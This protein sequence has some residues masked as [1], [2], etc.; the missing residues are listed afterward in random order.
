MQSYL[1]FALNKIVSYYTMFTRIYHIMDRYIILEVIN[2]CRYIKAGCY[3]RR[4]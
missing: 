2:A 1:L 3:K 4:S